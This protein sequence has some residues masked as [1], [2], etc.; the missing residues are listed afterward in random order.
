MNDRL[1]SE[2]PDLAQTF[3]GAGARA[4][5]PADLIDCFSR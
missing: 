4:L 1:A 2:R 3:Y 5:L